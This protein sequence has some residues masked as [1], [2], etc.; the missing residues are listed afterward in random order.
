MKPIY[1]FNN[2]RGATLCHMCRIIIATGKMV[3]LLFCSECQAK[4]DARNKIK[5]TKKKYV[6]DHIT[7]MNIGDIFNKEE[8]IR[9]L[10][11]NYDYFIKRSFDVFLCEAKKQFPD[12]KYIS[13]K[14][15]IKRTL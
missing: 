1:K 7:H 3:D 11:G 14:G 2:G 5:T 6:L 8:F 9:I 4:I 13:V 12:R 15:S 10:W